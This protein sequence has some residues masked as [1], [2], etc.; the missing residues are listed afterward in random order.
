MGTLDKLIT[1]SF[2]QEM[3]TTTHTFLLKL[4]RLLIGQ[5]LVTKVTV[6]YITDN[7]AT[8][9]LKQV[10]LLHLLNS[11]VTFKIT[12]L[13]S[14]GIHLGAKYCY[15]VQLTNVAAILNTRILYESFPVASKSDS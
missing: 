9:A 5:W 13:L 15:L 8:M 14:C 6:G 1:I 10:D 2:R 11:E 4:F 12:P 7:S 3:K